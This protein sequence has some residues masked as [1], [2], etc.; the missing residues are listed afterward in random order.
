M[1]NK[2]INTGHYARCSNCNCHFD[3]SMKVTSRAIELSSTIPYAIYTDA[4]FIPSKC[5]HCG[6]IIQDISVYD[7]DTI[8]ANVKEV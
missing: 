4:K 6:S 1:I 3:F 5:P 7:D 2:Q 8:I